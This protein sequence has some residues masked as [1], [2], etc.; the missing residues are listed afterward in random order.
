MTRDRLFRRPIPWRSILF[1]AGGAYALLSIWSLPWFP[2]VH[3]DEVWL[4]SL[5]R[6]MIADRSVTATEPFFELT[7]RHPHA[8]KT[9]YHLIQAPFVA[10]SFSPVAARMPSLLAGLILVATVYLLLRSLA[11]SRAVAL[12]VTAAAALD[13]SILSASHLGRQ[14][15]LLAAAMVGGALAIHRAR[16]PGM[17]A[18]VIVG[19]AI[20]IHPNAF[21]LS[22]ALLPW[23]G[24]RPR[25]ILAYAAIVAA[26]AALAVT[27]SFA[28]DPDFLTNHLSFGESVGVTASP[29]ARLF[30]FR[31]FLMKLLLRAAGTY[32]LPPV[33]A[34]FLAGAVTVGVSLVVRVAGWWSGRSSGGGSDQAASAQTTGTSTGGE[35]APLRT[36]PI[37]S[38]LATAIGIF[39]IGKYSPPIAV[40]FAPWIYL[41]TGLLLQWAQVRAPAGRL[42]ALAASVALLAGSGAILAHELV[43]THPST[44]GGDYTA[45]SVRISDILEEHHLAG[46]AV[47]ANLNLGFMLD[48]EEL[49]AFHDFASLAEEEDLDIVLQRREV[50]VVILPETEFDLIYRE[51]PV[52]NDLYGNPTRFV[53]DLRTLLE[54][55]GVRI[56]TVEAPV[57]GM[58]IV[59][60]WDPGV[61]PVLGIYALVRERPR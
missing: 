41:Q 18:G 33:R 45:L 58:R 28:M 40:F 21:I 8:I 11:V 1:V 10:V 6:E 25:A 34:T 17:V 35:T 53:P 54:R 26:F 7:P 23:V 12:S 49:L 48:G 30:G 14:E 16:R 39:L 36:T 32:Y 56:A 3:S 20:F 13:P 44:T 9:L 38:L 59:S 55:D 43:Q 37:L 31:A 4:A 15:A 5:T 29:L 50:E 19:V 24:R 46:R 57:Y 47:L 52:W 2:F 22:L 42:I 60:R 27:A 51:R 61:P